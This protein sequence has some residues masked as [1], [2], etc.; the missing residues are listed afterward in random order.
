MHWQTHGPSLPQAWRR[1]SQRG[2]PLWEDGHSHQQAQEEQVSLGS[3]EFWET[4]LLED[5]CHLPI[6]LW[7]PAL[8]EVTRDQIIAM[9]PR[10]ISWPADLEDER[11]EELEELLDGDWMETDD[12]NDGDVVVEFE[13]KLSTK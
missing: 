1:Q 12:Q 7:S 4:S 2:N 11:Q 5:T 13:G 6:L 9:R 3:K 8:K 10:P